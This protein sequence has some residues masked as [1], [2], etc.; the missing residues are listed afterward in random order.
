[1]ALEILP[2]GHTDDK[3]R[4]ADQLEEA[5]SRAL[6]RGD[7]ATLP[8]H[9]EGLGEDMLEELESM[10]PGDA[11]EAVMAVVR[12]RCTTIEGVPV[13]DMVQEVVTISGL[14]R[15]LVEE[16]LEELVDEGVVFHGRRGRV[17]IDGLVDETDVET[18]VLGVLGDL[19]TE[20]RGGARDDVVITLT[21][22]GFARDEVEEAIDILE[23]AGRLEEGHP[24]QVRVAMDVEE[25]EEVHHQVF[26]ALEEM[27][28]EGTGVLDAR[29]EHELTSRGLELEE[30]REALDDLVDTGDVVRD[31][32]EVRLASSLGGEAEAREL[33]LEVVH[34][35]SEDKGRPVPTI[36]ILR[37]ARSRG[38]PT[39]RA[40][41]TLEALMDAGQVWKDD[42]GV[43]LADEGMTDPEQA[44]KAV[45]ATVRDLAHGHRMGAS[46]I[47]VI[48][49][50]VTR[51]LGEEEARETLEDL[52]EGGLVH[53]AGDGYIR[54]G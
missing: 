33:M 19:S 48:D 37:A 41:R 38:M 11:R 2:P 9:P 7:G 28:T 5:R 6:E 23:E 50:A 36:T 32:G 46:R 49:M 15:E 22:R 30:V 24:G 54:P 43:H 25:I 35:L 4:M 20:G 21:S 42:R 14:E 44:R 40:H 31:G 18:A 13:R 27:D 51:G 52:L 53:E 16:A 26:A 3:S 1:M 47:E 45:L 8:P 29:L 12:R 39:A 10:G 34:A 17:M